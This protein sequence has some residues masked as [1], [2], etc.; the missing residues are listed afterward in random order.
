MAQSD[1]FKVLSI[2]GL[3]FRET[4]NRRVGSKLRHKNVLTALSYALEK[5]T[6]KVDLQTNRQAL[7]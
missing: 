4:L 2:T 6:I 5:L 1:S 7:R 3:Y